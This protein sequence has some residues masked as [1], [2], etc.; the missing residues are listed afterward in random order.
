MTLLNIVRSFLHRMMASLYSMTRPSCILWYYGSCPF[1]WLRFSNVCSQ[2]EFT[3]GV[4]NSLFNGPV[5]PD[6]RFMI[7]SKATFHLADADPNPNFTW[8]MSAEVRIHQKMLWNARPYQK[9]N[10]SERQDPTRKKCSEMYDRCMTYQKKCS[11]MQ[12]PI[13]TKFWN[14]RHARPYQKKKF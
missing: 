9:K 4:L 1:I 8:P 11:E 2:A 6:G 13:R 3:L 7:R 12:D 10:C 5:V 14:A